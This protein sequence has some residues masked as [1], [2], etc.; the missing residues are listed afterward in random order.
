MQP[1]PFAK[2]ITRSHSGS[3]GSRAG[4]LRWGE[5]LT[6]IPTFTFWGGGMLGLTSRFGGSRGTQGLGATLGRVGKSRAT[7]AMKVGERLKG[8]KK[9]A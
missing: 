4:S 7:V 2:F 9:W 3:S 8:A 1:A 5:I 6:R